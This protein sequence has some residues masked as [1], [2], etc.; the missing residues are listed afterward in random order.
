MSVFSLILY[1]F[2]A[3]T[4][5]LDFLVDFIYK[6]LGDDEIQFEADIPSVPQTFTNNPALEIEDV[7]GKHFYFFRIND[8]AEKYVF[9]QIFSFARCRF[10]SHWTYHTEPQFSGSLKSCYRYCSWSEV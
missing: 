1:C 2:S 8:I 9:R 7:E 10:L 6:L 3:V 4:F 5:R